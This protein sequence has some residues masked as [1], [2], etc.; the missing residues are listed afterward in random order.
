M[1]DNTSKLSLKIGSSYLTRDD[2]VIKIELAL[3][4]EDHHYEEGY[5]FFSN[6]GIRYRADGTTGPYPV[7]D[8]DLVKEVVN[9]IDKRITGNHAGILDSLGYMAAQGQ[10]IRAVKLHRSIYGTG[11][12]AAKDAVQAAEAE[13]RKRYN[14]ENPL[15][16]RVAELEDCLRTTR[17]LV[18]K[19]R[20][21]GFTDDEAVG[22]LFFNNGTITR[23]VPLRQGEVKPSSVR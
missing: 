15:A 9:L 1:A 3:S 11:L 4:P 16:R 7:S 17:T 21:N 5:R 8:N 20:E 14:F 2:T 19:C 23:L 22:K 13:A 6:E 10:L 12:K 18:S